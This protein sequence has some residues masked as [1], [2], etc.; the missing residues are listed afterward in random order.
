MNYQFLRILLLFYILI[1]SNI[2][3]SQ[4][5]NLIPGISAKLNYTNI[6]DTYGIAVIGGMEHYI[7]IDQGTTWTEMNNNIASDLIN[8][9]GFN[10]AVIN[11]TTMCIIGY[12]FT[13][14]QYVIVRTTDGGNTWNNV[15]V[16]SSPL[17]NL[18]DIDVNGNDLIVSGKNGIY[19][20][21][22][23]G[24]NWTFVSISTNNQ[25][26][27]FVKYNQSANSWLVGNFSTNFH[28][29]IDNGLTWIETNLGFTSSTTLSA[30]RTGSGVLLTKD[31]TTSTQL[32]FINSTNSISDTITIPDNLAWANGA[33]S[34][35]AFLPNGNL[36]TLNNF[37]YHLVY[38]S[39]SQVYFV[40]SP[41]SGGFKP[42]KLSLGSSYGIAY[43]LQN[44]PLESRAYLINYAQAPNISVP[45]SF[46][47][48]SPTPCAGD[49]II[50]TAN[51][52]YADSVKWKVNNVLVSTSNTLN[53]P[54]PSGVFMTYTV[55]LTT[56]YNGVSNV[57]SQSITMSA[58]SPPHTFVHT[59][60]TTACY[61]LPLNVF[62]NPDNGTPS[63]TAIKILYNGQLVYGPVTMLSNNINAYTSPLTTSGLLQIIS[64]KTLPCDPSADTI[65]VNITIGPNLED[66]TLIPN[67]T[68]ICTGINP[69]F[70]LT[71]TNSLY[72]YN[73]TA[74]NSP[75][76]GNTSVQSS[77]NSNDTL[78]VNLNGPLN[79]DDNT[80]PNTYGNIYMH[81]SLQ[82]S[83]T[84]GCVI[85]SPIDTIRI[86]RPTAY[87]DLHSRSFHKNDTVELSNA[88][89]TDNRLWTSPDLNGLYIGNNTG[90]VPLIIADTT[91]FFRIQL[92]NEPLPQCIDSTEHYIHYAVEADEMNPVCS[93]RYIHEIDLLHETVFDPFG[94]IY[95]IRATSQ[96]L[97]N[98]PYYVINKLDPEGNLLWEKRADYQGSGY[99]G[100]T[101]VGLESIDFD[102]E[103]N[104][105]IAY[106][107][108]G[109]D[110]FFNDY[111]DF[112][113]WPNQQSWCFIAKLD[114]YT[115]DTLW[116]VKLNDLPME[117]F[118]S[119]S[120]FRI[121][122]LVVDNEMIHIATFDGGS[123]IRMISLNTT[124]GSLI[125]VTPL[126]LT[127]SSSSPPFISYSFLDEGYAYIYANQSSTWSPQLEV[128]STGEVIAI[129]YYRNSGNFANYPQLAMSGNNHGVFVYKYHP[130]AG[131]YE[132]QK[133]A[134]IGKPLVSNNVFDKPHFIIDNND[135]IIVASYWQNNP[136]TWDLTPISVLDS[137]LFMGSGTFLVSMD[138]DYNMNWLTLGTNTQVQDLDYVK[139][140]EEIYLATTSKD[141]F[142]IGQ[143]TI[144]IM[145]GEIIDTSYQYTQVPYPYQ[146]TVQHRL[147]EVKN[148]AFL[149]KLNSNGEPLEMKSMKFSYSSYLS[150]GISNNLRIATSP[151]G[152]VAFVVRGGNG[153]E[154]TLDSQTYQLDSTRIFF[155]RENCS[156]PLCSYLNISDTLN[157]CGPQDS[158]NVQFCDYFNLDT[159]TYDF[160]LNGY[161]LYANQSTTVSDGKFTIPYPL[162]VNGEY[163][164][165][166]TFPIIDTL[167]VQHSIITPAYFVFTDSVCGGNPV[168]IEASPLTYQYDW[169]FDSGSSVSFD[170]SLYDI[171]I[172]VLNVSITDENGCSYV[173]S[174][175]IF[176]ADIPQVNFSFSDTVC[177]GNLALIDALPSTYQYQWDFAS[178]S[179]V[180]LDSSLY[181]LGVNV[182]DVDI[183]DE[184]GC[185]Y[186]DT[187][188]IFIDAC[189]NV[190]ENELSNY[191]LSPNPNDGKFSI[192]LDDF[193]SE[194]TIEI[195]D[196]FGKTVFYKDYNNVKHVNLNLNLL[197]ST[198]ILR[199][200]TGKNVVNELIIINNQ[201]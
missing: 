160:L 137:S 74:F 111:I 55:Q 20:S 6:N 149:T 43:N 132:V 173:D 92:R 83:D 59:V 130:N 3:F 198:Y 45:A 156:A 66:Y 62:I 182:L 181:N 36:L 88:Y 143:N 93:S 31:N 57:I 189:M 58:P 13:L 172:N 201:D 177:Y 67:D 139:N 60:D 123:T 134:Q 112:D 72:N 68:V 87:F 49:P 161:T 18:T 76:S 113:S 79:I 38:P 4:V 131:V 24:L 179:S 97:A 110:E 184:L 108:E 126:I 85:S 80:N 165:A 114:K 10:I 52:N 94:N 103:G 82:V 12:N 23:A 107:I 117:F 95:E 27:P 148:T 192:Y 188:E 162:N 47:V 106:W 14:G 194:L 116:R 17:N 147:D 51:A 41:T 155:M 175:Q 71:G 56:Y 153:I 99:D 44:S 42:K 5:F 183:T 81:I 185:N 78:T 150:N 200:I 133:I 26:S 170:S 186:S 135:N 191:Q 197:S 140:T 141:N 119:G 28:V 178:G 96:T 1:N 61:G 63:N 180:S 144:N 136:S 121:T 35:A 9:E 84:A 22:D 115:G 89:V 54:T 104:P 30:S 46:T 151:C 40:N 70:Q 7:S 164:V 91:G 152:D 122:D 8:V 125:N 34:T 90:T 167:I 199:L 98:N 193:Q 169:E 101:G 100:I 21:D 102:C 37:I 16:S 127:T 120:R 128:L 124:D 158:V 118:W 64:F 73:F 53:Y 109:D 2:S 105:Y 48:A 75:I 196:L 29:S 19:R 77:G 32:F 25:S 69:E 138:T 195:L 50:V 39:N 129:G 33:C 11:A 190:V 146:Y 142:S 86:Q 163:A 168:L 15:F 159:L 166:F 157:I 176:I 65:D 171:G 187:I 154:I 174:I 145:T